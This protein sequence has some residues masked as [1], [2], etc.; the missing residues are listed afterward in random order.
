MFIPEHILAKKLSKPFAVKQME[1]ALSIKDV[2]MTKRIVTGAYSTMLLYD[3][4]DDVLMPGAFNK[5]IADRGPD[6]NATAKIKHA[7]FHD[8]TR[9]PGKIQVLEEKVVDGHTVEYFETKMD[10]ST[11][12]NDTLI[13]YQEGVYDNHSIGFRYVEGKINLIERGNEEFEKIVAQTIN[14]ESINEKGYLWKVDE[15]MQFE[16]S[17]VS[18]GANELTP[19]LGV[20]AKDNPA[21][22][23]KLNERLDRL[24]SLLKNG[25]LSDDG[26]VKLNLEIAQ[27]KQIFAETLVKI[28]EPSPKATPIVE[29]TE[30]DTNEEAKRKQFYLNLL[31]S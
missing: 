23:M 16:G 3:S 10:T 28:Q 26:F 25:K 21:L 2:D 1:S 22:I 24:E 6:S 20:K 5:S 11:D 17:T 7:L 14:P 13:K 18:F 29:P 31:K 4:D 30:P 12:G 9:L 15:V 19:H 8:M 27:I